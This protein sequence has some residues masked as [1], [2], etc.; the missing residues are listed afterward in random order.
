MK[1]QTVFGLTISGRAVVNFL[2]AY[3][4]W[5]VPERLQ[6]HDLYFTLQRIPVFLQKYEPTC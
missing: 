6:L 5:F 1:P 3:F 4:N 2:Y